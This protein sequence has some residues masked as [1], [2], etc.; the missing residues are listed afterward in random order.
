MRSHRCYLENIRKT[1]QKMIHFSFI[2]SPPQQGPQ[3]VWGRFGHGQLW[4]AIIILLYFRSIAK[5]LSLSLS[6]SACLRVTSLDCAACETHSNTT[7][8]NRLTNKLWV[9]GQTHILHGHP[10]RKPLAQH[11]ICMVLLAV[12]ISKQ[13]EFNGWLF[14]PSP[15][16]LAVSVSKQSVSQIDDR[17]HSEP[18]STFRARFQ[19][20]DFLSSL[21]LSLFLSLSL[22]LSL[23]LS[24]SAQKIADL[25]AYRTSSAS[26]VVYG[27]FF[28]IKF[29]QGWCDCHTIRYLSMDKIKSLRSSLIRLSEQ[30]MAAC[31][32]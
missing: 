9:L 8:N 15:S 19:C 10:L 13:T 17:A 28:S 18:H 27:S 14:S 25:Q 22:S 32:L 30:A 29:V 16:L 12:R 2:F 31:R 24:Q 6:R 3:H 26:L 11:A 21:S 5:S 7:H 4:R 1:K 20:D 23:A